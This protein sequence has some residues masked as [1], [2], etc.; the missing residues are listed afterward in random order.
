MIT[1]EMAARKRVSLR[2]VVNVQLRIIRTV[3]L[4]VEAG[5]V[6]IPPSAE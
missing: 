6:S 3:Q 5:Q 2:S 1:E 4:L